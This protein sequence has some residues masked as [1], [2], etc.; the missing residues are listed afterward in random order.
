V[1]RRQGAEA[2]SGRCLARLV[3]RL[4]VDS[5]V[6]VSTAAVVI[7]IPGTARRACEA[8]AS[9]VA[10]RSRSPACR[11][12]AASRRRSALALSREC[13]AYARSK[14]RRAWVDDARKGFVMWAS[15]VG[16]GIRAPH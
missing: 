4:T 10:A 8:A 5:L 13:L 14:A 2:T 7:V 11:P 3:Q 12:W 9:T 15:V 6:D 1:D 16:G